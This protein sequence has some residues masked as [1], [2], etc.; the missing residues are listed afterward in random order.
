M[1][2][3][4]TKD[5]SSES[6]QKNQI[7]A[8]LH[9]KKMS[10]AEFKEAMFY[11][12]Q[13]YDAVQKYLLIVGI[14]ELSNDF[15]S[16]T[17][18][19]LDLN[20][21]TLIESKDGFQRN[22]RTLWKILGKQAIYGLSIGTDFVDQKGVSLFPLYYVQNTPLKKVNIVNLCIKRGCSNLVLIL[23]DQYP[24]EMVRLVN[25]KESW[26]LLHDLAMKMENFTLDDEKLATWCIEK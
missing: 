23:I 19:I 12:A 26:S 15:Y 10:K 9:N 20:M 8:E 11:K 14:K 22:L 5:K 3:K 4:I 1:G 13:M 25:Q 6:S 17:D 7:L 24:Q 21:K 18:S 16:K 2:N